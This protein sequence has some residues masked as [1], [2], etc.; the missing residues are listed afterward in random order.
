MTVMR[1]LVRGRFGHRRDST[2][3]S[4]SGDVFGLVYSNDEEVPRTCY[5]NQLR[6]YR[7]LVGWSV[8]W[9]AGMYVCMSVCITMP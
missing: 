9:L 1:S 7:D 8:G 3:A 6:R 2:T 4:P 5:Y